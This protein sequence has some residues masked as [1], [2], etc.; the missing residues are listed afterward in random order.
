MD[1]KGISLLPAKPGKIDSLVEAIPGVF[2]KLAK[3]K[4][5]LKSSEDGDEGGKGGKGRKK[6][7]TEDSSEE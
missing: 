4:D 6:A 5:K 2:S 1:D 7:E 3:L